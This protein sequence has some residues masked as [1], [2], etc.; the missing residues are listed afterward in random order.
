MNLQQDEVLAEL[1]DY[2]RSDPKPQDAQAVELV[3]SYLDALN[4]I[5]ILGKKVCVF[6][7]NGTTLQRMEQGFEFFSSRAKENKDE[8][9]DR[10]SFL[11]WQVSIYYGCV[12]C[13][14]IHVQ[15]TLIGAHHRMI[16]MYTY[17]YILDVGLTSHNVVWIPGTSAR[18]HCY[19]SWLPRKSQESRWQCCRFSQLKH[20]TSSNLTA[21][22][23]ESAKA[24]LLTRAQSKGK[25]AYRSAALYLR[26][27]DLSRKP[28]SS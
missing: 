27:S 3:I 2:A 1:K 14:H 11:A 6:D 12:M 19:K 17:Y 24:T 26:Q 28:K 23:Y 10:K 25:D 22:N 18:L 21:A 16:T 4:K 5:F 20:T 9:E 13:T 15:F 8:D 7:A